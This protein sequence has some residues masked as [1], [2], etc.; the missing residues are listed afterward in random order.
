MHKVFNQFLYNDDAGDI[1]GAS[2]DVVEAEA[3][4]SQPDINTPTTPLSKQAPEA[5]AAPAEPQ[6]SVAEQPKGYF[7][8]APEDWREQLISGL[9]IEDAAEVKKMMNQLQ[10]VSDIKTFAKNY[11][12]AQEKIRSGQIETGLPENATDEQVAAYREANGIPMSH[13]DYQLDFDEGLMLSEEDVRILDPVLQVAH[14][15]NVPTSAVNDMVNAQ[16]KARMAEEERMLQQDGLDQQVWT[17]Q[18]KEV[19]GTDYSRNFN[20]LQNTVNQ[21]PESI[22][23]PLIN[24]RMGNGKA[25]FNSPE[26][27]MFLA[28]L[29]MKANPSATVV[30]NSNNPTRAIEDR[31]AELE[32]RMGSDDTWFKDKNAQHELQELYK[33]QEG[34]RR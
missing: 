23:E 7:A 5:E 9:G 25:L 20:I 3:P 10:R 6:E 1:G 32:G 29:A 8:E 18:M 11:F 33:A 2:G 13:R 30:P 22:R 21:M 16:L 17:E 15:N 12:S 26:F 4:A 24:A 19:W 31:I 28:D 34:M 27:S 14:Q